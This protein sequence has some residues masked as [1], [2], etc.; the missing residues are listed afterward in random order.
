MLNISLISNSKNTA[1]LWSRT[2][3]SIKSYFPV[4][5]GRSLYLLCGCHWCCIASKTEAYGSGLPHLFYIPLWIFLFPRQLSSNDSILLSIWSTGSWMDVCYRVLYVRSK[6]IHDTM[7]AV[8]QWLHHQVCVHGVSDII[9]TQKI[10]TIYTPR[11]LWLYY[12]A[13]AAWNLQ[14][15]ISGCEF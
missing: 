10:I 9:H 1:S 4:G 3:A 12:V 5:L 8:W 11:W 15:S 7:D 6:R 13:L 2:T 14:R